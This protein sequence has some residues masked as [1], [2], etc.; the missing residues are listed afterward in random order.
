MVN[1]TARAINVVY[2]EWLIY[3]PAVASI[4][5]RGL[6]KLAEI[7]IKTNAM[8]ALGETCGGHKNENSTSVMKR[9]ITSLD[10]LPNRSDKSGYT[11]ELNECA[12]LHERHVSILREP[13]V[14]VFHYV[15]C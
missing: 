13:S 3:T 4:Y 2:T 7:P 14:S 1:N 15:C 9:P 12:G 10:V 5:A 11:K 8:T 6:T